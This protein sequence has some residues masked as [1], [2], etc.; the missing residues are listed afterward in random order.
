[1]NVSTVCT[2]VQTAF[3]LRR[4][5]G[6][7]PEGERQ[8][9]PAERSTGQARAGRAPRGAA[10]TASHIDR[11]E[12]VGRHERAAHRREHED[13]Q[14][15]HRLP[16]VR[17]GRVAR[18]TRCPPRR[19]ACRPSRRS[20]IA[21]KPMCG[22]PHSPSLKTRPGTEPLLP[23]AAGT[24]EGRERL[25]AHEPGHLVQE[26]AVRLPP[27]V[28]ERHGDQRHAEDGRPGHRPPVTPQQ[29][30]EH[31]H[32]GIELA[33]DREGEERSAE[34]RGAVDRSSTSPARTR[35]IISHLHVAGLE[36]RDD[37]RP[38]DDER[39][40]PHR[41]RA[42]PLVETP[43]HEHGDD[44]DEAEVEREPEPAEAPEVR[45]HE[46]EDPRDEQERRRVLV[47][48]DVQQSQLAR[49]AHRRRIGLRQ[50]CTALRRR[51]RA[52]A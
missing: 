51:R 20:R 26:R 42:E 21:S 10:T 3:H 6:G 22:T 52:R 5:A 47:V 7:G 35:A 16:P 36:R 9:T 11:E 13:D 43:R 31:E 2:V 30:V 37:R 34:R 48:V 32:A 45:C 8:R 46:A 44:D 40:Q 25:A 18:A 12:R 33:G 23:I 49:R 4:D 1:M 19:R 15:D 41:V 29:Q 17:A 28:G 39:R 50:R 14:P 27:D 38:G 24:A